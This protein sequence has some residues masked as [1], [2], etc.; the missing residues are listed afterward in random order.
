MFDICKAL[1]ICQKLFY[2]CPCGELCKKSV[3]KVFLDFQSGPLLR[4][5]LH[6]MQLK[7]ILPL[8]TYTCSLLRWDNT[9]SQKD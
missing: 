5:P 3:S 9:S 2:I 4:L 8:Y 1:K 6:L 7:N